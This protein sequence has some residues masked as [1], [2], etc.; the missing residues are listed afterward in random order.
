AEQAPVPRIGQ[1]GVRRIG[2][3]LIG[4]LGPPRHRHHRTVQRHTAR[5][6]RADAALGEFCLM[7][8]HE[9]E[10]GA[11]AGGKACWTIVPP[12]HAAYALD[13]R[14]E[15]TQ[16]VRYLLQPLAAE[17]EL[18]MHVEPQRRIRAAYLTSLVELDRLVG[19]VH[20]S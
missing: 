7:L 5:I 12:P 10:A 15:L 16:E 17:A 13:P 9:V 8:G 11:G 1:G 19:G 2:P 3:E 18:R 14:Q 20:D 6:A 4:N